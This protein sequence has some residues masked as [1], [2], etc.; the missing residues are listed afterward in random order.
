MALKPGNLPAPAADSKKR[1]AKKEMIPK[2]RI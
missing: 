2:S 1:F